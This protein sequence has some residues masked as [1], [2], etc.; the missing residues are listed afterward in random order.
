M[1][2]TVDIRDTYARCST[3]FAERVHEVD[4]RWAAPTP[5]PGWDVRALVNHLVNEELWAPELLAGSTIEQVG[6]RFDG[7]LLGADPVAAFDTAAAAALAAVRAEGVV[8]GTVAL[9]S[10]AHPGGEYVVALAADHLVHAWDL[11]RAI[12]ADET[13][14]ATAVEAVGEWFTGM[15][16][17]YRDLGVIGPRVELPA[18]SSA[19]DQ[20]L[21]MMGRTP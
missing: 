12:G 2:T 13:L 20:L 15:E 1:L 21:A 17:T 11:A 3:A 14:D 5:L 7:D 16:A 18:G 8:E 6:S 4:G 10:G 9:S 19:Q